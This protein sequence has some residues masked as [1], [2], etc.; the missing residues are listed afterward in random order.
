MSHIALSVSAPY[1]E[2]LS[3]ILSS[4]LFG[5]TLMNGTLFTVGFLATHVA[6]FL[7]PVANGEQ[8][9][10]ILRVLKLVMKQEQNF[11][12]LKHFKSTSTY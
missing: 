5:L 3:I 1:Q 6:F 11:D 9:L 4:Q 7:L 12:P 10:H 8:I 2:P